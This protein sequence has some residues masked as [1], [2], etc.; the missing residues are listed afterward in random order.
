MKLRCTNSHSHFNHS[1]KHLFVRSG[2]RFSNSSVNQF[3]Y[4]INGVYG[5]LLF[6]C[7]SLVMSMMV[8]FCAVLFPTRFL[9]E[10]LNLI[11]SVSEGFPSTFL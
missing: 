2:R 6:T 9:D 1:S 5:K 4:D 3:V 10:I 11:E 7:L 8:S